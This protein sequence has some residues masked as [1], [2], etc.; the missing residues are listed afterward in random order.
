MGYMRDQIRQALAEEV[1]DDAEVLH[2]FEDSYTL[3]VSKELYDEFTGAN[4]E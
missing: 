4:N 1:L 2:E 3:R